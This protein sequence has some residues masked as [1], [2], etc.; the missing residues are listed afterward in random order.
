MTEE[1]KIAEFEKKLVENL[2]QYLDHNKISQDKLASL[3]RENGYNISQSTISRLCS[4][5]RRITVYYLYAICCSLGIKVDEL[6]EHAG[7]ET[8]R[9]GFLRQGRI[10]NQ[11]AKDPYLDE[12]DYDIYLGNYYIYYLPTDLSN[13]YEDGRVVKGRL[14][15]E[16]RKNLSYCYVGIKIKA[17]GDSHKKE[18]TFKYYEGQLVIMKKKNVASITVADGSDGEFGVIMMCHRTYQGLSTMECKIGVALRVNSGYEDVPC[19]QRVIISKEALSEKAL[20]YLKP[21]FKLGKDRVLI[22]KKDYEEIISMIRV[23]DL[24]KEKI[25][26]YLE[27]QEY[28]EISENILNEIH[29][30]VLKGESEDMFYRFQKELCDKNILGMANDCINAV[31]DNNVYTILNFLKRQGEAY[32]SGK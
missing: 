22:L 5:Q 30:K 11:I 1:N 28:L 4:R 29:E 26:K 10:A 7:L 2:N 14:S 27:E 8:M 9:Q 16:R 18:V 23:P 24:Q 32:E 12:Q 13:V 3:C 20:G 31:Q 25:N 19:V 6:I 17:G 21:V 15:I